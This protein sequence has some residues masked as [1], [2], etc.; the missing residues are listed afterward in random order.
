MFQT[1]YTEGRESF[2][3]RFY[4]KKK[5]PRSNRINIEV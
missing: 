4:C 1:K 3:T 5:N 2:E